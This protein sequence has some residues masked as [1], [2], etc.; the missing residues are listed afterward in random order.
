MSLFIHKN[1]NLI[2]SSFFLILLLL[3]SLTWGWTI[4][5][6]GDLRGEDFIATYTALKIIHAGYGEQLYDFETQRQF[7]Q[8][9]IP[10]TNFPEGLLP[11]ITPPFYVGPFLPL[12][13]LAYDGALTVMILLNLTMLLVGLRW[14]RGQLN[15]LRKYSY[16]L[17]VVASLAFFPAFVNLIQGQNA[18]FT[19]LIM[20]GSYLLFKQQRDRTA[21]AVLA[22]GL[23]KPQLMVVWV[24]VLLFKRRWLALL[25]FSGVAVLLTGLSYLIVGWPG[26]MA[27][28]NLTVIDSPLKDG[29]Y[30]IIK[31]DQMH[32][33]RAIFRLL[34]GPHQAVM[35]NSLTGIASL[36][37]LLLL[38][39]AWRGS[40]QP[41]RPK[42]DLQIALT[43]LTALLV[44]PHLYIHDLTLWILI[45]LLLINYHSTGNWFLS[46]PTLYSL[47]IIGSLISFVG[48]A[49]RDTLN[50]PLTTVFMIFLFTGLIYTTITLKEN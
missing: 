29:A 31:Y 12:G 42:F 46:L 36:I 9:F 27:Y 21:G 49:L 5:N 48:L 50:M 2:A 6:R 47:I 8:R 23:Y 28:L 18:I 3:Y 25:T 30:G 26:M 40:W 39:W 32:N 34:I 35:V 16:G 19:L 7:Q 41:S 33:W 37:N 24:I 15:G 1:S 20:S 10:Q 13:W 14:L 22:L 45:G 4:L 11:Y 17:L 38:A 43:C 44:S